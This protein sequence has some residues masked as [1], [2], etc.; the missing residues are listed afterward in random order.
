L[1]PIKHLSILPKIH[2]QYLAL[3][4]TNPLRVHADLHLRQAPAEDV[5]STFSVFKSGYLFVKPSGF[6]VPAANVDDEED[7]QR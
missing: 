5:R 1:S 2:G 6:R 3:R 7:E 4:L